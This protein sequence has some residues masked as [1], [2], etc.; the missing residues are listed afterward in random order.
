MAIE[1][2]VK[3]NKLC[4]AAHHNLE[5]LFFILIYIC[6]NSSGPGTIQ[7]QEELQ[8]HS[9]TDDGSGPAA[10]MMVDQPVGQTMTELNQVAPMD[11]VS[12]I[13]TPT[14]HIT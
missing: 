2:L 5:S 11:V 12:E 3:N 10:A 13:V 8:M 6:T 14:G 7:T 1:L 9:S 4:H